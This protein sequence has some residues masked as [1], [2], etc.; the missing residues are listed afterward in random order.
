MP[1]ALIYGE[2]DILIPS[3]CFER[4]LSVLPDPDTLSP[5][6]R[7]E[8]INS[9][10]SMTLEKHQVKDYNHVDYMWAADSDVYVNWP[11]RNFLKKH[12][13]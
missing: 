8:W 12:L 9:G 1:I 11:I 5:E 13:L 2:D 10:K 7:R 4:L 3:E 6:E